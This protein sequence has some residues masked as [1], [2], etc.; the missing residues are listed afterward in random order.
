MGNRSWQTVIEL[1]MLRVLS[2]GGEFHADQI[3]QIVGA[4]RTRIMQL[5]NELEREGLASKRWVNAGQSMNF[6]KYQLTP[7]G[8]AWAGRV[9]DAALR[10]LQP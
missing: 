7:D 2:R 5:L 9:L 1:A 6:K 8:A 3:A 4:H 10:K